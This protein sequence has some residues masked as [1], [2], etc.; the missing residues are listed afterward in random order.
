MPRRW[1]GSRSR[2]TQR[3]RCHPGR[4]P[5]RPGSPAQAWS[6]CAGRRA[7]CS[8][9][10]GF[11]ARDW[12][13][14]GYLREARSWRGIPAHTR[15]AGWSFA[16]GATCRAVAAA[17]S[18]DPGGHSPVA[19][20]GQGPSLPDSCSGAPDAGWHGGAMPQLVSRPA[21]PSRWPR[22]FHPAPPLP[23]SWPRRAV[24]RP[25]LVPRAVPAPRRWSP[26]PSRQ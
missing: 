15:S 22:R 26:G 13:G 25:F 5:S 14:Y 12:Y 19:L 21:R 8:S 10:A 24:P 4:M 17:W 11:P 3:F 16:A 20:Q 6:A 23:G 2:C 9:V 1:Q 18:A 7:A